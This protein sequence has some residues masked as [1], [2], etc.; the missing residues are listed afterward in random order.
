MVFNLKKKKK[1]ISGRHCSNYNKFTSLVIHETES[2][3][4]QGLGK[5]T[6]TTKGG[7]CDDKCANVKKVPESIKHFL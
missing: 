1:L 3:L 7:T 5:L 4:F 6:N 2:P